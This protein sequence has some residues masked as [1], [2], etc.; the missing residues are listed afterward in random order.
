MSK[1]NILRSVISKALLLFVIFMPNSLYASREPIEIISDHA[2]YHEKDG[3]AL[4]TG[5]V[6]ALQED[7]KLNSDSLEMK[8]RGNGFDLFIAKGKK[9][10]AIL[11]NL[12]SE[13]NS[14]GTGKADKIVY[15][16]KLDKVDFIGN[17]E[18][19]QDGYTITGDII[20]YYF[21]DQRLVAPK[22]DKQRT[23]VVLPAS[24][25]KG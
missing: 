1:Q 23:K 11:T 14:I 20:T 21:E 5:N 15:D 6:E 2:E 13:E 22:K 18:V 16:T 19:S 25:V 9:K 3:L 10:R 7:K 12:K 24:S 4:Y 8:N 17:A